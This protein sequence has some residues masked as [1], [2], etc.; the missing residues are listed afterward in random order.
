MEFKEALNMYKAISDET[1]LTILLKILHENE[2]CACR[3]L[4]VVNCNQATLSHHMKILADANLVLCRKE[5]KWV[6]YSI[7]KEKIN[8]LKEFIK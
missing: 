3:L 5:W 6:H 7:N 1:R 4:E 2:I 8:E